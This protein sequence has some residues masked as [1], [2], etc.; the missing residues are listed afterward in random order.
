MH[1]VLPQQ[2]CG[3]ANLAR[4]QRGYPDEIRRQVRGLA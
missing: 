3:K 2:I 4:M 1:D